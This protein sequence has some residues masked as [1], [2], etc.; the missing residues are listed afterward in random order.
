MYLINYNLPLW[1]AIKKGHLILSLIVRGKFK[2]KNIDVYL[3][4]LVDELPELWHG[5]DI[6]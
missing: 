5:I 1:L 2:A 6:A 4:P 3:A